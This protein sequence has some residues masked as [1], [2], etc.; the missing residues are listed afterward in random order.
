MIGQDQSNHPYVTLV[1]LFQ[2]SVSFYFYFFYL[3]LTFRFITVV[4]SFVPFFISYLNTVSNVPSA[5]YFFT[6][7]FAVAVPFGVWWSYAAPADGTHWSFPVTVGDQSDG[8][9]DCDSISVASE[10]STITIVSDTINSNTIIDRS[11]FDLTTSGTVTPS[12]P[13]VRPVWLALTETPPEERKK[14]RQS[15]DDCHVLIRWSELVLLVKN[16]LC[17][18]CGSPIKRFH[19]RTIGIATEIDFHCSCCKKTASALADRRS[20]VKEVTETN[21]LKRERK[22]ESYEMNWRLIMSTQL[23]GES[24]I[25]G[26]I[27]GMFIDLTREA[28]RN[29]W[30]PMEDL[31]G[32]E[33]REIGKQ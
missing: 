3:H 10:G 23:M 31:L 4:V 8:N 13:V 29:S 33:Q 15:P 18:S 16:N 28:F 21:F 12:S 2:S 22:I 7:S 26:S 14:M 5:K 11:F 19:R 30:G 20:D 1:S 9:S 32:V 27:I 24:Q 6:G 25:G 17:C